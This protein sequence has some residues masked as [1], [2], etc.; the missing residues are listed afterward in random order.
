MKENDA[1]KHRKVKTS[2]IINDLGNKT[3]EITFAGKKEQGSIIIDNDDLHFINNYYWHI[4]S[5][6]NGMRYVEGRVNG[7]HIKLHRL[8]MNAKKGEI[9]D[10]I[11]RNTLNNSRAN[12]SIVTFSE[13]NKNCSFHKNNKSGRMGVYRR[14]IKNKSDVYVAKTRSN[15]KEY[16]KMFSINKYGGNKCL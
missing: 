10:H 15:G 4:K 9:V 13:N 3:S 7:K 6:V 5:S 16:Q 1:R 2:Q 8:L 14:K 11:D 12:L